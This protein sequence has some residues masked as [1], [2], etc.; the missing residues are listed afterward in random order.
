MANKK[1]A[2]LAWTGDGLAFDG[3]LDTGYPVKM[4]STA[5]DKGASPMA[6][7]LS[8]V[9]GCTAM[10]VLS[11]VQKKRQQVDGMEI[12]IEGL[13]AD[14]HPMVYTE[15][16]IRYILYGRDI[17]PSAVERAIELSQTK[18]CSA[19]ITFDRAGVEVRTHYEIRES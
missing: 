17:D 16:D 5:D 6:L 9:A 14:D 12:E 15:V 19:S 18:Y 10:D 3:T 13:R 4:N 1:S 2:K 7:F 11:I 8:S